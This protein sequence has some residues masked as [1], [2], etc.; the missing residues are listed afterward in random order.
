MS[1]FCGPFVSP[2]RSGPSLSYPADPSGIIKLFA[3]DTNLFV[4]NSDYVTLLLWLTVP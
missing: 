1:F 2:V 4:Q 3:D